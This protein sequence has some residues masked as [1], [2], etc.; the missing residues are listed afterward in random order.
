MSSV[1]TAV[2][3]VA[4][5]SLHTS[6][7]LQPGSGD[8]GGMNVYVREVAS[9]L[10][11]AGVECTTYTRADGPGLPDEVPVE[12][13]HRV[14]HVPAGPFDLPKEALPDVRRRVHRPAC[15]STSAPGPASTSSTATTGSAASSAT[16]SSTSSACRS[17]R[18]STRW[19]GS[20]PRAATSSPAW[21]DRAEAEVIG[22]S[23][24]ICVSCTEE[25]HQFRRLYGDPAGRIEIVPPGVEHAFFAPGDRR[26]ARHAS[27]CRRPAGAAVRRAD[28]AAEGRPTSPIRALAALTA[29]RRRAGDRRRG[30]RRRRRRRGRGAARRWSTSSASPTGCASCRRSRTTSCRSYYR[31]ADVVHRARA[32]ARASGSSPWRRRRAACRSSPAPS[33]GCSTLVDDG[34]TGFLVDGRDPERVRRGRS[35]ELL[36]DP[37]RRGG[38][39][40]RRR[41]AGPA[42]HVELHGGPAAPALHRPR[43]PHGPG[44]SPAPDVRSHAV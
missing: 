13:G 19:P 24:A 2:K 21:R 23:D 22:C 32:A 34:D 29:T 27:A 44:W 41:R 36:D 43:R 12:P 11:Q 17:C 4:M 37:A 42:V 20:R 5:I 8:S 10:A 6:P 18:R 16:A 35:A 3:R 15:S 1:A 14:V 30:Q 31:A 40:R 39:G 9:A 33:A 38:D 28:P 26:G 7:L 25:E